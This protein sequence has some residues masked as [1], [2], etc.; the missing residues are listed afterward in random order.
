MHALS[1]VEGQIGSQ[2]IDD[3]DMQEI[4]VVDPPL[5]AHECTKNDV[6]LLFVGWISDYLM[7]KIG[8]LRAIGVD[9]EWLI[10]HAKMDT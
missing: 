1:L 9:G 10:G 3:D 2:R 4:E 7:N 8:D 5:E 6:A